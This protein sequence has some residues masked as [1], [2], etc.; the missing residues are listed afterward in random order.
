[1]AKIIWDQVGQRLYE[2][3]ISQGVFYKRVVMVFLGMGSLR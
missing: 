3:G 1:M 2:T